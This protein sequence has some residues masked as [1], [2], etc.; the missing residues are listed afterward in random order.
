MEIKHSSQLKQQE[1]VT[2]IQLATKL[3]VL[4][5]KQNNDTTKAKGVNVWII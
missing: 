3:V 1:L 2:C 5:K 4:N